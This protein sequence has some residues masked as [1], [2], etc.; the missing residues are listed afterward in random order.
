MIAE[1][2]KKLQ[3]EL[4]A[5]EETFAEIEERALTSK[6]VKMNPAMED[7]V[8]LAPTKNDSSYNSVNSAS[9]SSDSVRSSTKVILFLIIFTNF[10]KNSV[11]LD[12]NDL[13]R[14]PRVKVEERGGY[15]HPQYTDVVI[16]KSRAS[17]KPHN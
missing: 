10:K 4:A 1:F 5:K 8:N 16:Y 17:L 9:T 7:E 2:T 11:E 6:K 12:L 14:D 13:K 15:N 3:D